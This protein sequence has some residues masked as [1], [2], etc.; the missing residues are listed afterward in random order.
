ML[1]RAIGFVALEVF[2]V[3]VCVCVLLLHCLEN[4]PAATVGVG[5]VDNSS[6][7]VHDDDVLQKCYRY[8]GIVPAVA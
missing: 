7:F 8:H 5:G 6:V 1:Q 2:F 4:S 3:V